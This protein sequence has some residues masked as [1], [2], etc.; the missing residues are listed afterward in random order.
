MAVLSGTERDSC[1]ETWAHAHDEG[2]DDE[3]WGACIVHGD[4]GKPFTGSGLPPFNFCPW[5]G[6]DKRAEAPRDHYAKF[7]AW[8]EAQPEE[9]RAAVLGNAAKLGS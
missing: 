1:C 5:C 9:T 6:A 3:R 2:T 7:M 4:D 8:L